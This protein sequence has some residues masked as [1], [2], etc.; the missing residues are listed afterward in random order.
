MPQNPFLGEIFAA[1]F[2]FAPQGYAFCDGTL[3]PI[4][5]NTAL[6]S[7]LG[8][9]FGGDGL[10]TF[11]LPDLR[12]RVPVMFGQGNGLTPYNIGE[13]G[14][15]EAVTLTQ[16]QMPQHAHQL[17]G[18]T[19]NG[20]STSPANATWAASSQ[21]DKV[22][23]TPAGPLCRVMPWD[24]PAGTSPTRTG[25]RSSPSITTSPCKGS[26][27]HVVDHPRRSGMRPAPGVG[28]VCHRVYS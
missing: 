19:T 17:L 5:Q 10:I 9:Q 26:S 3:L 15:V 23:G 7:L 1:G 22:Y 12:S 20:S 2:N 27:R 13:N 11:G 8:T 6:F 25:R 16:G 24:P 28:G 14:G 21:K 18:S 4:S